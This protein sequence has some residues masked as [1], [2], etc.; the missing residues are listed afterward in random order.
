[1][2]VAS[3]GGPP[4]RPWN[5]LAIIAFVLAFVVPPG[6]IVCTQVPFPA[7]SDRWQRLA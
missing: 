6:G 5:A 7:H 3:P 4:L 1:M 2:T